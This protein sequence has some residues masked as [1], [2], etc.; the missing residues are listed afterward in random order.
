MKELFNSLD[1]NNN[2]A[3]T[4]DEFCYAYADKI[5]Q[6]ELSIIECKNKTVGIQSQLQDLNAQKRDVAKTETLNQFGIMEG[7]VLIVSV[8]EAR[9]LFNNELGGSIDPFVLLGCEGQ[10]IETS[11]K[12]N[13]LNPIYNECFTFDIKRGDDPLKL[14]VWDRGAFNNNFVGKFFLNL[15]SLQTQNKVRNWYD[16]HEEN[17][18]GDGRRGQIRLEIQWI[19][20]RLQLMNEKVRE[21]NDVKRKVEDIRKAYERELNIIRSPFGFL[22]NDNLAS[23]YEN[24][25]EILMSIYLAHPKE[26]EAS[27]ALDAIINPI[28]TKSGLGQNFWAVVFTYTYFLYLLITFMLCF[29]KPD[30]INLTVVTLAFYLLPFVNLPGLNSPQLKKKV[31]RICVVL[32]FFSIIFDIIWLILHTSHWWGTL[33]YDGDVEKTMRRYSVVMTFISLF[34]RLWVFL[35]FWKMS[36]DY[37]KY[38]NE[39]AG[40]GATVAGDKFVYLR[41]GRRDTY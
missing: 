7:S 4:I 23:A 22:I 38:T 21:L 25:P 26:Q 20:S 19:Y 35:V 34:F 29:Y 24:E 2:K 12:A 15:D 13:T 39:Q 32:I 1:S 36:L 41:G 37:F 3:I 33:R 10:K 6:H 9:N 31:I 17:Y 14:T 30:F 27:K 16:L 18:D 28:K 5:D 11:Y 40:L 8:V